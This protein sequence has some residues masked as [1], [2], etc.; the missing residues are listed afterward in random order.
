MGSTVW[1]D[2]LIQLALQ[3]SH[4][5][6]APV[7]LLLKWRLLQLRRLPQ[8]RQLRLLLTHRSQQTLLFCLQSCHWAVHLHRCLAK[9]KK[10]R[11]CMSD[12]GSQKRQMAVRHGGKVHPEMAQREDDNYPRYKL[13]FS[14]FWRV[15]LIRVTSAIFSSTSLLSL[16]TSNFCSS[17]YRNSSCLLEIDISH[18]LCYENQNQPSDRPP[19]LSVPPRRTAAVWSSPLPPG[20]AGSLTASSQCLHSVSTLTRL[21]LGA[22]GRLKANVSG[23][24]WSMYLAEQF[25][26]AAHQLCVLFFQHVV[27]LLWG[28]GPF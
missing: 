6:A 17:N 23:L 2:L 20:S 10:K 1:T 28:L 3:L 24:V 18:P 7:S 26:V 21:R 5:P 27:P 14:L 16:S 11:K 25:S 19:V 15:P 13:T 22:D 9:E 4:L 12:E 8:R